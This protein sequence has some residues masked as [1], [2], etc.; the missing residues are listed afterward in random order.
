MAAPSDFSSA[1]SLLLY[2]SLLREAGLHALPVEEGTLADG[3]APAAPSTAAS[4]RSPSLPLPQRAPGESALSAAARELSLAMGEMN[5]LVNLLALTR[6]AGAP[7]GSTGALFERIPTAGSGPLS[8][9]SFARTARLARGSKSLALREASDQLLRGAAAARGRASG[10]A[11]ALAGVA[12]LS[13]RGWRVLTADEAEA[14]AGGGSGGGGAGALSGSDGAGGA[15]RAQLPPLP[16]V[17][18]LPPLGMGAG[19]GAHSPDQAGVRAWREAL[20]RRFAARGLA[21]LVQHV[22]GSTGAVGGGAL[23]LTVRPPLGFA[24][25]ALRVSVSVLP[26]RLRHGGAGAEEDGGGSEE[27]EEEEEAEGNGAGCLVDVTA[28][29]AA[30]RAEGGVTPAEAILWVVAAAACSTVA[31]DFLTAAGLCMVAEG[32]RPPVQQLDA[33]AAAHARTAPPARIVIMGD[34]STQV[35]PASVVY[36][37]FQRPATGPVDVSLAHDRLTL[38]SGRC[39]LS[40]MLVAATPPP[41]SADA[42]AGTPAARL[43]ARAASLLAAGALRA[44]GG[45]PTPPSTHE[46][47]GILRELARELAASECR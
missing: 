42:T 46:W 23:A 32:R 36:E 45:G 22:R 6:A 9:E 16:H 12:A 20:T 38:R 33:G 19:G 34:G 39:A 5:A 28:A 15:A 10:A 31:F 21:A 37:I 13:A 47:Q 29:W 14:V 17:L 43:A 3:A 41:V 4:A 30:D 18:C 8:A 11:A 35:F 7:G 1:S 25:A 26:V 44:G 2:A 27:E 40:V 24:P